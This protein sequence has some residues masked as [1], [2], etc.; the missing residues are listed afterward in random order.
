MTGVNVNLPN[1]LPSPQAVDEKACS[2]PLVG[3][4]GASIVSVEIGCSS[5]FV[6]DGIFTIIVLL[7]L[8][9]EGEGDRVYD[10][11]TFQWR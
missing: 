9:Y 1:A 4:G 6:R 7:L 11:N 5:F 8:L 2:S 3:A 10:C